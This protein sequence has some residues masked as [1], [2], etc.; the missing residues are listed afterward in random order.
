VT[1]LWTSQL[2]TLPEKFDRWAS[3]SVGLAAASGA[4]LAK[5]TLGFLIAFALLVFSLF[6][7]FRD[8]N[9]YYDEWN[10]LLPMPAGSKRRL[11][12]KIHSTIIGVVRG[13]FITALAQTLVSVV[14]FIIVGT[15]ALVLLGLASFAATIIPGIGPALI[16]A[17]VA[18][19]YLLAGSY[20]RGIFLILWGVLVTGLIDNVLRPYVV[21]KRVDMPVFWLFL[22]ILGGLQSFGIAGVLLGPLVITVLGFLLDIYRDVYLTGRTPL[23]D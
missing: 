11:D 4:A 2:D 10:R 15:P 5:N 17:P 19:Y 9:R 14:G 22:S 12:D 7:M 6:F 1:T 8:G 20:F 13:T 3:Q 23:E 21:G 16:W 18:I